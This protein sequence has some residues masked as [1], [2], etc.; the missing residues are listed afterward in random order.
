MTIDPAYRML[1]PDDPDAPRRA[2]RLREL[3]ISG[4][5]PVPEFDE[6]ARH[7][8]RAANA[9]F[10]M[11]NIIGPHRQ[12]FAGLYPSSADR[13]VDWRSDA[14]RSMACDHGYCMHVLAR[15]HALALPEVTG[16]ARYAVNP[17]V[18]EP[19]VRAYLGAPLIDRDGSILGTIC[20]LD[21][22]PRPGWDQNAVEWIKGQA[23]ELASRIL[24]RETGPRPG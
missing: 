22:E 3:G 18:T 19:G 20:V 4:D 7:L 15:G 1:P 11:V 23:R 9:K 8:A 12:Y 21:T 13:D 5:E 6:F 24:R 16:I 10:A 14:F 2:G 17:V